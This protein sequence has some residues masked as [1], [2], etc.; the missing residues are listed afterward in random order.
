MNDFAPGR[1]PQQLLLATDLSPR[2][3][4][5]LDR[6]RQ[7]AI[8]WQAGLAVLVVHEGP[9]TPEEVS[10]WLDGRSATHH[11]GIAMRAELAAEFAGTGISPTLQVGQGD[12]T[13]SILDAAAGLGDALVIIGASRNV[14]FQE[15]ILGNAA[16]G[17]VQRLAHP[18]LVV[19]QRPRSAYAR[20]LVPTDLT[21]TCRHALA[22][23]IRL[24]PER[25]ITLLHVADAGA[26]AQRFLDRCTLPP[27]VRER[28]D[29]VV[30]AG[31]VTEAI[32]RHV[33]DA[34]IDLVVLGVHRRSAVARVFSESRSDELLQQ[35]PCDTLLVRTS[36][37]SVSQGSDDG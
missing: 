8:E 35:L 15:L 26:D 33:A 19:R 12:V 27:D 28:I 30:S 31:P 21:D 11:F 29:I 23:A 6:T 7:L 22:T 24:F 34:A 14:S 36:E 5:A 25:R 9:A 3:D 32:G 20:I 13:A 4:R 16:G 18:L 1:R 2:D 17:L 37:R 10:S